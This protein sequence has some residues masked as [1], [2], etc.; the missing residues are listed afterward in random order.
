MKVA[1]REL[2]EEWAEKIW[3]TLEFWMLKSASGD[4]ISTPT[5]W[6]GPFRTVA[7]SPTF[8]AYR[9]VVTCRSQRTTQRPDPHAMSLFR[10][11]PSR[12]D[13]PGHST[14]AACP[15]SGSAKQRLT[16]FLDD[17][18]TI[19]NRHYVRG[20]GDVAKRAKVNDKVAPAATDATGASVLPGRDLL[21]HRLKTCKHK[22]RREPLAINLA[23]ELTRR[24]DDSKPL[25]PQRQLFVAEI[26]LAHSR[27][28][29]FPRFLL[30]LIVD[31]LRSRSRIRSFAHPFLSGS[32]NP[33]R[34]LRALALRGNS[35]IRAT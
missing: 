13:S 33:S 8:N 20:G 7:R 25:E 23:V 3:L 16:P 31:L 6:E 2:R 35:H 29:E 27:H 34:P 30:P 21:L 19:G 26:A 24:F 4:A 11:P 5:R 28:D 14:P 15:R 17:L 32:F 1:K 12:Q 18:S 9:K 10:V 22:G